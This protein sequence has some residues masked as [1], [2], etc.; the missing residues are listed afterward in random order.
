[1]T[2]ISCSHKILDVLRAES[3]RDDVELTLCGVYR[4][5]QLEQERRDRE[6]ALRLAAEDQSMVEDIQ[7]ARLQIASV[8]VHCTVTALVL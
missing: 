4:Q 7:T 2:S 5:Q 1:M 6:L 3:T 8:G